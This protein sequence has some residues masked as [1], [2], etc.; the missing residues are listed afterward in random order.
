MSRRGNLPLYLLLCLLLAGFM[1]GAI[2]YMRE[3]R[4]QSA[5]SL[6]L[7]LKAD[8]QMESAITMVMQKIRFLASGSTSLTPEALDLKSQEIAPGLVLSLL[9][10]RLATDVIRFEARVEGHGFIRRLAAQATCL[11]PAPADPTVPLPEIPTAGRPRW[12]VEFLPDGGA[13]PGR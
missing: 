7:K 13:D 9:S 5:A 3:A 4:R 6:L 8:Y 10:H 12:Q 11:P 1:S 2:W